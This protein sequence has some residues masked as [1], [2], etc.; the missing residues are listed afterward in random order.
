MKREFKQLIVVFALVIALVAIGCI[1]SG[2]GD[3]PDPSQTTTEPV[4][5]IPPSSDNTSSS[6]SEQTT[7]SS[8]STSTT[9]STSKPPVV[10]PPTGDYINPL[11][12]LP[13][14]ND[15]S[16]KRPIAVVVDN[17]EYAYPNQAGLTQADILYEGLVAP[18]ITRFMAVIADYDDLDKIC[19]I[20][21]GRDY[22][23]FSALNHDAILVCHSGAIVPSPSSN[24]LFA[25]IA[26][27]IYGYYIAKNGKVYYGYV[28]TKDESRF[29]QAE[30]GQKYGTIQHYGA[31]KDLLYDT[32][33]DSKAFK[34]T[35]KYGY[36]INASGFSA[37]R[38]KSESLSFMTYGTSANMP[39]AKTAS[40]VVIS[41]TLEKAAG[42]KNVE[43]TYV[44]G[45]Y[46]RNQDGGVHKD[47]VTG[48]QL[49][50]KNLITLNTKVTNYSGTKEDPNLADIVTIGS[51]T[52]MYIS[53]GKAI[54]IV[55]SKPTETSPLVL[56]YADGTP[57][58]LNAGNTCISFV[59]KADS[60]SVRVLG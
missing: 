29:S 33:F 58:K 50:F 30:S 46:Y 52:G 28:N 9:A 43:Y 41:F 4:W 47:A 8:S 51:G 36:C 44:N 27:R 15:V 12:G 54:E 35:L 49:S 24:E 23:I 42:S 37:D 17:Y 39:N 55:W 3:K 21:S 56:T 32:L 45:R 7:T 59:N 5:T 1:V 6:S 40:S 26:E 19:N 18:G 2:C 25:S 16:S 34:D 13:C 31:R 38:S 14:K 11:T 20:R 53:E 22:H 60:N 57:L 10:V 48:V